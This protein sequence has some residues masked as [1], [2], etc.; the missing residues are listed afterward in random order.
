VS[1]VLVASLALTAALTAC[2]AGDGRVQLESLEQG[3]VGGAPTPRRPEVGSY[4]NGVDG[5]CT[6]T[7]IAPKYVLTAAH[8]LEPAY[9]SAIPPATASFN[10]EDIGGASR[11]YGIDRVFTFAGKRWEYLPDGVSTTDVALVRLA[12]AI[13]A[14]QAIPARLASNLPRTGDRSTIFGYG[15]TDRTPPS[16]GGYLQFVSFDYG[17]ST[18]ALCWGD[19]GGPVS[20]GNVGEEGGIWGVN[21]DFNFVGSTDDDW[22]DIFGGAAYLKPQIEDIM[23]TWEG[24]LQLGQDYPGL[25]FAAV[26]AASASDCA[27]ACKSDSRCLAFTWMSN[28]ETCRLKSGVPESAPAV[29]AIS[30]LAPIYETDTDRPGMDYSSFKLAEPRA[31][32]CAAACARDAA[33]R[34][35][36]YVAPV[37]KSSP[38]CSLKSGIPGTSAC[39]KCTSGVMDRMLERHW[40][41][42]GDDY[43]VQSAPSARACAQMCAKSSKCL[44]FT[45]LGSGGYCWLKD[46]VPGTL[47]QSDYLSGVRRGL[48]ANTDR[49]GGDYRSF[50]A[51]TNSPY[52]CQAA[53]ADDASCQA[54]TFVPAGT[55]AHAA[56]SLKHE[57]PATV[58]RTGIVS[59]IRGME[60]LS[61]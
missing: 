24:D 2:V 19:S 39:S 44:S 12:S 54:W 8:C 22:T 33:C 30:G 48:E 1:E 40:L 56:C 7:I 51:T 14:A 20:Y 29:N 58:P 43:A 61:P 11:V 23:R 6:A 60:F 50:R 57:V 41:R 5:L 21:S 31:E 49:P 3:L 32:L 59:G 17:S 53:C 38:Q 45:F 9:T 52:E 4:Y 26:R 10:F 15:C 46:R 35:W 18:T 28:T 34:A 27:S 25:D 36:T 55:G 13:P 47:P 42:I 16:G 37:R